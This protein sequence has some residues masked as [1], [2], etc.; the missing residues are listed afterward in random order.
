MS[1]AWAQLAEPA[2]R[3]LA[4]AWV[5]ASDAAMDL[6]GVGVLGP[7]TDDAQ[8]V[9][10][11]VPN[12]TLERWLVMSWIGAHPDAG[13]PLLAALWGLEEAARAT[14]LPTLVLRLAPLISRHAPLLSLL[15]QRPALDAR[16]ARALIQPV[17]EADVVAGIARFLTGAG[18]WNDWYKAC[19]PDAISVGELAQ[20]AQAGQFGQV[21]ALP[22]WE[23]SPAVLRA[24]G[25]SEQDA[26][27]RAT[28][29]A[30]RSVLAATPQGTA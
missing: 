30:P 26:W 4:A 12:D 20:F 13:D 16:L 27:T 25:L 15:A 11:C 29:L 21:A 7:A 22:A 19:G 8:A 24:Q 23:P 14:G 10:P 18:L 3:L 9:T 2:P 5:R 6:R 17:L 1:P 28:G